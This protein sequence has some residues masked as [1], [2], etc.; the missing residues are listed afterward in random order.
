MGLSYWIKERDNPQLGTYYVPC[1]QMTVKEAKKYERPLYGENT[2][3][4]FETV[5]AYI[6]EIHKLKSDGCK[7]ND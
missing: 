1:G 7:V 5:E 3:H 2:M 6:D 4:R